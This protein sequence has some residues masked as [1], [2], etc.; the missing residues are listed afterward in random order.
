VHNCCTNLAAFPLA[1]S[2]FLHQNS[3]AST[4]FAERIIFA[5]LHPL[6]HLRSARPH[7]RAQKRRRSSRSL[8]LTSR[9][10]TRSHRTDLSCGSSQIAAS[11]N[12][13]R[14]GRQLHTRRLVSHRCIAFRR[15]VVADRVI[16]HLTLS[17]VTSV[18]VHFS[19][20]SV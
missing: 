4:R 12:A 19:K 7:P 10:S 18:R 2:L 3:A 15:C 8:A 17:S 9:H 20:H 11:G 14:V 1:A 6:V 5:L 16:T 13:L